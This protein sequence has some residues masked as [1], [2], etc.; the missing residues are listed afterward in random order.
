VHY[1]LTRDVYNSAL[2]DF[3]AV[4]QAKDED[5][6]GRMG[7]FARRFGQPTGAAEGEGLASLLDVGGELKPV[8]HNMIAKAER[9]KKKGG[10]K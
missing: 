8:N 7:R 2:W 1:P 5:E 6:S 10:K 9:T 4:S 3:A